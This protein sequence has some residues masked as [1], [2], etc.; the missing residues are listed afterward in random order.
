MEVRSCEISHSYDK[1]SSKDNK[2]VEDRLNSKIKR[3][4]FKMG[5]LLKWLIYLNG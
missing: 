5:N 2:I 3:T 1:F 4:L